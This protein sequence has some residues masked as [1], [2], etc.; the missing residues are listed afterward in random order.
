MTEIRVVWQTLQRMMPQV[1]K[2]PDL[3]KQYVRLH[4]PQSLRAT[5]N[6][7]LIEILGDIWVRLPSKRVRNPKP[8]ILPIIISVDGL[9]LESLVD[10]DITAMVQREDAKELL[11]AMF[12]A[13][14]ITMGIFNNEVQRVAFKKHMKL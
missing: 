12:L 8:Q 9:T 4:K 5:Q 2:R 1:M 3:L 7:Y 6:G 11:K 14:L 13:T 10:I